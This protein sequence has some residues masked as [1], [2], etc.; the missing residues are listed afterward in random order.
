[1]LL[2]ESF[3]RTQVVHTFAHSPIKLLRSQNIKLKS[4]LLVYSF[5]LCSDASAVIVPPNQAP[6]AAAHA[7]YTPTS[8]V[9]S[10]T[11]AEAASSDAAPSSSG[12]QAMEIDSSSQA[13][14]GAQ[15]DGGE[16]GAAVA[17]SMSMV[18]V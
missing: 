7:Q 10:T 8:V 2:R 14:P 11:D 3:F 4:Q 13:A 12:A 6:G 9:P 1:M 17:S 15:Q 18:E 5:C 16:A